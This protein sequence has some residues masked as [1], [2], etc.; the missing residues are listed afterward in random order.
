MRYHGLLDYQVRSYNTIMLLL[1]LVQLLL[2]LLLLLA[3][4]NSKMLS[5]HTP[6]YASLIARAATVAIPSSST[7]NKQYQGVV[8]F[9]DI[10]YTRSH[11][12]YFWRLYWLVYYSH[13]QLVVVI[14]RWLFVAQARTY[15]GRIT[16][17]APSARG[18]VPRAARPC[19]SPVPFSA[20]GE[21]NV[22]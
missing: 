1:I 2:P 18:Y 5:T 15:F 22:R 9:L 17:S 20:A 21:N 14:I 10:L 16:F 6:S 19:W 7:L 8:F 3:V 12:C 11:Y 4:F 13:D